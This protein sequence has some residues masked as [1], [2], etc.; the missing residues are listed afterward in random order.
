MR[1]RQEPH[2]LVDHVR[3]CDIASVKEYLRTLI[4]PFELVP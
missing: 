3:E 2:T 4:D 1:D